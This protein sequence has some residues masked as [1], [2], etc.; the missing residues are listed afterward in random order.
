MSQI[1]LINQATFAYYED[2]SSN[3]DQNRLLVCIKKA[4]DLDLKLFM[5]HAFYYDFIKWFT[6]VNGVLTP[7][8][9]IPQNYTNLFDG[10]EYQDRYGYNIIYEG[11]IP[12]LV[13]WTFARFIE[14]D[15]VRYTSTGPVTKQHDSADAVKVSDIVKLVQ[16][17]RS[18]ANAHANEIEKFLFDNQALYPLWRFSE[19][20]K[21]SR[22]SG[23]RIRGVDKTA[24]N[25]PGTTN[26]GNSNLP[27]TEFLY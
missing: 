2:L 25:Y 23:P 11:I 21:S 26:T 8:N 4:Q 17:Q 6:M 22:Q 27:L 13:Y 9:G 19:K 12:A 14:A 15:A 24:F 10:C 1:Y 18:V 20:N 7:V 3:I 5:G 16:Q